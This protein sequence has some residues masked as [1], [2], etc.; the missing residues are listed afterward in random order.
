MD[1]V[2]VKTERTP[3]THTKLPDT[4]KSLTHKFSIS[5]CKGYA[6]VGFYDDGKLGEIFLVM[7]KKGSTLSGFADALAMMM[8]L[9]LQHGVPA[10]TLV[11]KLLN[12]RFEPS[13]LTKNSDIPMAKSIVDYLARWLATRVLTQEE[14]DA[15]GITLM[16]SSGTTAKSGGD[17][18]TCKECGG[19][20]ARD[21]TMKRCGQCGHSQKAD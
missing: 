11:R 9:A 4:R 8:S 21:G 12:I 10:G 6:T 1:T 19:I 18:T 20:M 3:A 5:D 17:E 14:R 13:G 15:A 2:T 7:V 16:E